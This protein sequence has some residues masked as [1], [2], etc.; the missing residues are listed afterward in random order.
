[1]YVTVYV[2]Q[3][4]AILSHTKINKGLNNCC[5]SVTVYEV[6]RLTMGRGLFKGQEFLTKYNMCG[7]D[8]LVGAFEFACSTPDGMD[9]ANPARP[10]PPAAQPP[11]DSKSSSA[12]VK[13]DITTTPTSTSGTTKVKADKTT[14]PTTTP[15]TTKGKP[16][17]TT[18]EKSG[19]SSWGTSVHGSCLHALVCIV[20]LR[21]L[22][23]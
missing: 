14:T 13:A 11:P 20:L 8:H 4:H 10:C 23:V 1:M 19:E 12:T 2:A 17:K 6:G 7:P 18:T 9:A 22:L 3:W 16:D 21:V 5:L 15:G